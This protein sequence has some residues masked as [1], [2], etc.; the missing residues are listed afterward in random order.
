MYTLPVHR[1]R[2]TSLQCLRSRAILSISHQLRSISSAMRSRLREFF[3]L[4]LFLLPYCKHIEH[5][6]D[7]ELYI[8]LEYNVGPLN[9]P[10]L[11]QTTCITCIKFVLEFLVLGWGVTV[12]KI[13]SVSLA[14][15]GYNYIWNILNRLTHLNLL[16]IQL[17]NI[18]V[19]L[20]SN[21]FLRYI[22]T[23]ECFFRG[24][25]IHG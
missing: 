11:V 16:W 14:S 5:I 20:S 12:L 4:P 1:S 25:F 9:R 21:P 13:S 22:Q 2:T 24:M 18:D 10:V 6:F 23:A 8:V 7:L 3:G 19:K 17:S 15:L